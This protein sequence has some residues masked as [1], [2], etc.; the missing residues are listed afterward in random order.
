[1]PHVSGKGTKQWIKESLVNFTCEAKSM[2]NQNV[3]II[4]RSSI[5]VVQWSENMLSKLQLFPAFKESTSKLLHFLAFY[6]F[7]FIF[8]KKFR[9]SLTNLVQSP[10]NHLFSMIRSIFQ[11]KK[12]S[13]SISPQYKNANILHF[14]CAIR[15]ELDQWSVQTLGHNPFGPMLSNFTFTNIKCYK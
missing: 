6:V 11:E 13:L 2:P 14:S 3:L 12:Q 1:M 10:K 4:K 8:C 7:V 9:A 5:K 15:N